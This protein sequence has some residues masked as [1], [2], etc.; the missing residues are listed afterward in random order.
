MVTE[1]L[2]HME[3][4]FERRLVF[5]ASGQWS[6]WFCERCCWNQPLPILPDDRNR[7]A[8]SVKEEFAKHDCNDFARKNWVIVR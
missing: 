5:I 8:S 6:G 2:R 7:R 3:W 4:R 1:L